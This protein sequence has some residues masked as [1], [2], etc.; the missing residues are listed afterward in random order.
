MGLL[1]NQKPHDF[2]GT[3][4]SSKNLFLEVL[5]QMPQIRQNRPMHQAPNLAQL[6]SMTR[7]SGAKSRPQ[8]GL[9]NSVMSA[10]ES[11]QKR[12]TREQMNAGFQEVMK[13]KKKNGNKPLPK[14]ELLKAFSK[15]MPVM[16]AINFTDGVLREQQKRKNEQINI[17]NQIA[18]QKAEQKRQDEAGQFINVRNKDGSVDR[19]FRTN[20]ELKEK[21]IRISPPSMYSSKG[22]SV[23]SPVVEDDV[24]LG[25][26]KED[27]KH[28][29]SLNE[30]SGDALG[31]N[32]EPFD[33]SAA[34]YNKMRFGLDTMR[35]PN[36]T[37]FLLDKKTGATYDPRTRKP[38]K[39]DKPKQPK[40]SKYT[41]N[42]I[43]DQITTRFLTSVGKDYTQNQLERAGN[44]VRTKFGNKIAD[45]FLM[46][47]QRAGDE[48][49]SV[50]KPKVSSATKRYLQRQREKQDNSQNWQNAPLADI[51]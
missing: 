45:S 16:D 31:E 33:I 26:N 27:Y 9:I 47:L 35:L 42:D 3:G 38:I 30:E 28:I 25:Y 51:Y 8:S 50:T 13:Q 41:D 34:R 15:H 24:I 44:Q 4:Q 18:R 7:S 19:V 14:E 20:K 2:G 12:L 40:Q 48:E 22:S 11:Q 10:R 36:G 32:K 37:S 1:T 21:G 43:V 29:L 49:K 17:D 5:K 46:N 39:I 23:K 6:A